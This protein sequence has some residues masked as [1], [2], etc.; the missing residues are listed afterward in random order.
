ML[1]DLITRLSLG[2][3]ASLVQVEGA[4][5]RLFCAKREKGRKARLYCGHF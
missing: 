5:E 1:R 2:K 4:A 3:T